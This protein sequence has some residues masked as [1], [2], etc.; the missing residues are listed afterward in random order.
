MFTRNENVKDE[1]Q[2]QQSPSI[3]S[4]IAI[5][6]IIR[7]WSVLCKQRGSALGHENIGSSQ[8]VFII[9]R[10]AICIDV[11]DNYVAIQSPPNKALFAL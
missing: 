8:L 4:E 5:H 11:H 1:W 9:V 10:N 7:S 2:Q 6:T 3:V